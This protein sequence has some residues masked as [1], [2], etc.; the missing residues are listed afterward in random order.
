MASL[1]RMFL[2]VLVAAFVSPAVAS[3]GTVTAENGA[4]V[5]RAAPGEV[6]D[7]F[8]N[9][10]GT[11]IVF[12]DN[13]ALTAAGGLCTRG[14]YEPAGRLRCTPQPGGVRAELGDGDDVAR[15]GMGWTP[16]TPLTI[17]GGPG[18]DQL[19]GYA[20]PETL[21]GGDGN[22]VLKGNQGDDHLFGG[23][24]NDT[25]EG[26]DGADEVRGGEGDDTVGGGGTAQYADIIDGGP[27][28]DTLDQY[29][30]SGPATTGVVKLTLGGGADDGRPGENDDVT[31]VEVVK[32]LVAADITP[33]A[34]P[35]ELSVFRTLALPSRLVGTDQAD[36]L[37]GFDYDDTILGGAGDDTIIG[38][39]GNDT[40]NPGPGRDTVNADAVA[41]C[42]FLECR[43]AYGND[44][45][46]ARDGEVDTITC[47]VGQD[48]VLADT[49][50]VVAPD[51]ETVERSA[52]P[53]PGGGGGPAPGAKTPKKLGVTVPKKLTA[54]A[55]RKGTKLAVTA[56]KAGKLTLKLTRK[57]RTYAS[58]K[59]TAKAAGTFKI[60]L[61]APKSVRRATYR[62]TLELRPKTGKATRVS[63][64]VKVG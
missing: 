3:A 22:D 46:D 4:L 51:C 17:D 36:L 31:N 52:A 32:L 6:N 41:A 7:L 29:E 1:K 20:G 44:T 12:D 26:G 42:N 8:I 39:Y 27:G 58:G 9:D 49:I 63:R 34:G 21:I 37:T 30:Y 62:L 57:G 16:G 48:K 24:G 45:I 28:R 56:P 33:G 60:R 35:V 53:A 50:D 43:P 14:E 64:T 10:E 55:L 40:I 23:P 2:A 15:L 25:L 13:V 11:E 19:S 54:K 47:G 59:A 18:N 38:G 5:F 61:R